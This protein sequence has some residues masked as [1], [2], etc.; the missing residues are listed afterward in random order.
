M[1]PVPL[2][3][4]DFGIIP[5][6]VGPPPPVVRAPMTMNELIWQYFIAGLCVLIFGPVL[7][8]WAIFLPFPA[9]IVT[10]LG[11]SL[12]SAWVIY[13]SFR[14]KYVWVELDGDRI[15]ARHF[16]TRR[17]HERLLTEI[18]HLETLVMQ[19]QSPSTT[20]LLHAF[21]GRV[22]GCLFRFGDRRWPI[23]VSRVD[24]VMVNAQELIEAIVYRMSQHAEIDAELSEYQG[25][26]L[27]SK[28]FWRRTGPPALPQSLNS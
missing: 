1:S 21:Y 23:A 25:S 3:F 7:L 9:N 6:R 8:G 16:L 24:P 18:D 14:H 15:R 2:I 28:I 5:D 4:R 13:F 26:P 17:T 12:W 20:A 19:V 10:A 11:G 27:V 22:R